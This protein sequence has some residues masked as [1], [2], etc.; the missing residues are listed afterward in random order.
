MRAL[1]IASIACLSL[2]C[3]SAAEQRFSIQSRSS[4]WY[5]DGR[6]PNMTQPLL[7][8]RA[9]YND[10]HLQWILPTPND[11]SL[12]WSL[13]PVTHSSDVALLSRSSGGYLDG[14]NPG[15]GDPLITYR[16]PADDLVL[17]WIVKPL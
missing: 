3:C 14:R 7:T 17:H 16:P 2:V 9:P 12:Q 13:V 10:P 8:D 15:M 6:N 5:L 11:F 1:L 4:G